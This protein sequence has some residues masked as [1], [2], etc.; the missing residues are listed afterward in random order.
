MSTRKTIIKLDGARIDIA[1][2]SGL[3]APM[4]ESE[5]S[6]EADD[7]PNGQGGL[8]QVKVVEDGPLLISGN[9]SIIADSGRTRWRDTQVALCRCG[10]S[11][12]KPFCDGSHKAVGFKSK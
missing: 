4:S 6:G 10:E 3:L 11:G 8:L 1:K 7:D 2:G 5:P 12:N 9:F